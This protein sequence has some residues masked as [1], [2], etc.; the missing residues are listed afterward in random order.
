ME[1]TGN[2]RS[3]SVGRFWDF[4]EVNIRNMCVCYNV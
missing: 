3:R 1:E 4:V 2:N